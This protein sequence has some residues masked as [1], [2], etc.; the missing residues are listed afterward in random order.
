[1]SRSWHIIICV[2]IAFPF[3]LAFTAD[4]CLCGGLFSHYYLNLIDST[5]LKK[6]EKLSYSLS[7][8]SSLGLLIAEQKEKGK[9]LLLVTMAQKRTLYLDSESRL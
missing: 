6:L 9:K 2:E 5:S 4:F 3:P 8:R 1:M 7:R